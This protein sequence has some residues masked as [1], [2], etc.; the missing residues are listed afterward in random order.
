M[1]AHINRAQNEPKAEAREKHKTETKLWIRSCE[2]HQQTPC[3]DSV[4]FKMDVTPST[5]AYRIGLDESYRP[6]PSLYL[7][8]LSI[9]FV[10]ACSW[11]MNT[12]KNR[13][14]QVHIFVWFSLISLVIHEFWAFWFVG[15]FVIPWSHGFLAVSL[16][17]LSVLFAYWECMKRFS[18]MLWLDAEKV[19]GKGGEHSRLE[20]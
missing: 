11:T 15:Y 20:I 14:F 9:W 12:Y 13:H 19:V 10:S 3:K 4:S 5:G 1:S 2:S 16:W 18:L 17:I 7:A 6:L 8:F